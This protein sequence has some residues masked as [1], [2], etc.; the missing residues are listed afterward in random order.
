M[1]RRP[2]SL[3]FIFLL[4]LACASKEERIEEFIS[5]GKK[6]MKKGEYKKAI[7]EFKNA[8]QLDP[9]NPKALFYL[10]KAYLSLKEFRK[11]YSSFL[12]A[13]EED[14]GYDDARVEIA[15]L[16]V[17]ARRVDDAFE[18]L[19][20]IKNP[21][22]YEPRISIIKAR[23]FIIKERYR[24]A[25]RTLLAVKDAYR[26]KKIQMLLCLCYKKTG[27]FEKMKECIKRW[28]DIDRKDP[29][30]YIFMAQYW[31][32]KGEKENAV[33]E[34][35]EM[36]KNNPS[37]NLKLFRALSLERLGYIKEA[38]KA[39]EGLPQ[40][41]NFLKEK[42]RFYFRQRRIKEAE[43][44]LKELIRKN[45]EDIDSVI[46]LSEIFFETGRKELAYREIEKAVEN[47]KKK[48]D[49]ERLLFEKAKLKAKEGRLDEAKSICKEILK[50]DQAML[51]AHFLLGK[52][53]LYEGDL[54]SA[55]VH[56]SQV[57]VSR[58]DNVEAQILLSRCQLMNKKPSMAE[59]TLKNAIS[60]MP[61]N[62]RLRLELAR[63][64]FI[65]KRYRDAIEVL[66]KGISIDPENIS[67]LKTKGEIELFV[68][69]YEKAK[70]DFEKI[71]KLK[72]SSS[73]GFIE[74]G[75]LYLVKGEYDL[76]LSFFKKAYEKKDG[77]N[78]FPMIIETY[79][80]KNDLSSAIR[81]CQEEIKKKPSSAIPYYFLGRIYLIKKEMKKA[82]E[83]FLKAK[84][85]APEWQ[86]P[87][88]AIASLYLRE[89]KVD[90]A[91][92]ELE[93]AF[94]KKPAL[95][96]GI[97][98]AM[99]YEHKKDLKKAEDIYNYLL[100]LYPNSAVLLNN[101]AYF[102]ADHSFEKE[103]LKKARRLIARVLSRYPDDPNFLDTAAWVEYKL[104]NFN[105]AWAYIQNAVRNSN[106][107]IIYLHAAIIA[108]ELGE[109]KEAEKYLS[110]IIK[111][112][113]P[114]IRKKALELKKCF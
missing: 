106:R 38:E 99:L 64:Y 71:I 14:P 114:D 16:L 21:K 60:R 48:K 77:I 109:K 13:I 37:D 22:N 32:Q 23:A 67:L 63:F 10:G 11:A 30:S 50:M 80:K 61:K 12:R 51:D 29:G 97:S 98:L 2:F 33:K 41:S 42:A 1:L 3:F 78:A 79:L 87:Y 45:P 82:K 47:V 95:H 43:K 69:E 35:D 56:L 76:A 58:P 104:K 46:I 101:L 89:G 59:D 102:Y 49:R 28:R 88:R 27:D 66:E 110:K 112:V 91:I 7:L 96:I 72:P 5:D 39:F 53:L 68:K 65:R 40:E 36:I 93:R 74:L 90:Q 92:A 107:D 100:K 6:F 111:S 105:I 75:R 103:K 94:K 83:M 57:A 73:L 31:M 34:L 84:S 25:I 4:I 15:S 24:D 9:K 17:F 70:R 55:E 85:L 54:D 18:H 19:K 20:K 26:D 8:L 108:Y 113:D 81:F 52:I 62:Q 86:D 44:I